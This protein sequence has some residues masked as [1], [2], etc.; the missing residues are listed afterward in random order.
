MSELYLAVGNQVGGNAAKG[1]G[2]LC[3]VDILGLAQV[4]AQG[5]LDIGAADQSSRQ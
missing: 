2:Q 4:V 3:E 5:F 1:A